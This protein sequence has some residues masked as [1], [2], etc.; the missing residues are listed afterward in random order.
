MQSKPEL[1][2][3]L[4]PSHCTS[5]GL[6]LLLHQD[7]GQHAVEIVCVQGIPDAAAL[8][9]IVSSM[10][11]SSETL[12]VEK[13]NQ[14]LLGLYTL[15]F[16]LQAM[17]AVC[18]GYVLLWA[19]CGLEGDCYVFVS[20]MVYGSCAGAVFLMIVRI[21]ASPLFYGRVAGVANGVAFVIPQKMSGVTHTLDTT[22]GAKAYHASFK[23]PITLLHCK[24]QRRELSSYIKLACCTLLHTEE[25]L[26]M[27]VLCDA[28]DLLRCSHQVPARFINHLGVLLLLVQGDH[29]AQVVAFLMRSGFTIVALGSELLIATR[30]MGGMGEWAVHSVE[31]GSDVRVVRLRFFASHA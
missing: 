1:R 28:I 2:L 29:L 7:D 20:P 8:A 4:V 18:I 23:C 15:L 16:W 12:W 17:C 13:T 21:T 30:R 26:L 22:Q 9:H 11:P 27:P 6:H 24:W 19:V 5:T 25:G 10:P 3:A 14:H 31:G